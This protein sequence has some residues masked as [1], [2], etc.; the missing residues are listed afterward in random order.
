[1]TEV[2]LP[3]NARTNTPRSI[4]G[5]APQKP[6]EFSSTRTRMCLRSLALRLCMRMPEPSRQVCNHIL[7]GPQRRLLLIHLS[8]QEKPKRRT[9]KNPLPMIKKR[10]STTF[11][12]PYTLPIITSSF[13]TIP[14]MILTT[15]VK[16]I[17]PTPS[18]LRSITSYSK[19]EA[20]LTTS[21]TSTAMAQPK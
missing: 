4:S 2:G 15:F 13:P 10:Q 5:M 6:K 16:L 17:L 3:H 1:M 7:V 12:I 14:K 18:S 9:L 11:A 19:R 20:H 21:P 8:S